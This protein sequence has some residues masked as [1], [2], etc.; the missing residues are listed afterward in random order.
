VSTF[1]VRSAHAQNNQAIRLQAL[2]TLASLQGKTPSRSREQVFT[3]SATDR[4]LGEP[5]LLC[6]VLVAC[7]QSCTHVLHACVRVGGAHLALPLPGTLADEGTH[8]VRLLQGFLRRGNGGHHRDST[9]GSS[10]SPRALLPVPVGLGGAGGR[11]W[12]AAQ[13][14]KLNKQ[15]GAGTCDARENGLPRSNKMQCVVLFHKGSQGQRRDG[16]GGVGSGKASAR[17]PYIRKKH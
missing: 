17:G 8:L 14:Y 15:Q 11:Q 4:A 2:L 6:I 5:P 3:C 1:R 10:T 7:A 12:C 13:V 9:P 16:G